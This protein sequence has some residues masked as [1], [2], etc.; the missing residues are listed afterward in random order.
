MAQQFEDKA[1]ITDKLIKDELGEEELEK[2][3]GG[4]TF[5][6][7]QTDRASPTLIEGRPPFES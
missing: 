2:A 5:Y 1:P 4:A 7:R 3:S 6:Y